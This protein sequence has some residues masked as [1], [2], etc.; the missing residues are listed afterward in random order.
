M[1]SP[2]IKKTCKTCGKEFYLFASYIKY[3]QKRGKIKGIYCSKQ[4]QRKPRSK[5]IDCGKESTQS[6][7][8]KN[9]PLRCQSCYGKSK[10]KNPKNKTG[11]YGSKKGKCIVCHTEISD[12]YRKFCRS[13]SHKGN[14]NHKWIDGSSLKTGYSM[15]CAA[16]RKA[17]LVGNGGHFT[18]S[19]WEDLKKKYE[20]TCLCCRKM[21]PEIKLHAD[22]V[23]PVSRG[24][25]NDISNIQ[26]LCQ[27]CNSKKW[28][29]TGPEYD[30]RM[31]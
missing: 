17:R 3:N 11:S 12:V 15:I 31:V 10:L 1:A 2:K 21:E 18:L 24:G 27:K 28:A 4:C 9:Q 22:H 6:I 16:K 7:D 29:L 23:I 25:V 30:F 19:E 26:P 5:C 20:Y 8:E 14:K 13:C